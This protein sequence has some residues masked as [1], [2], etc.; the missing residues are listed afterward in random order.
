L[1]SLDFRA[2]FKQLRLPSYF[3]DI[4]SRQISGLSFPRRRE[5]IMS[6]SRGKTGYE[7]VP[8]CAGMTEF[9]DFTGRGHM[10]LY[11][12]KYLAF[13]R[14]HYP[15]LITGARQLVAQKNNATP[16][17]A[18]LNN[19]PVI[20]T[21]R[22]DQPA[23]FNPDLV[24]QLVTT[25]NT[26]LCVDRHVV[27]P[28]YYRAQLAEQNNVNLSEI[29]TNQTTLIKLVNEMTLIAC[30]EIL[31]EHGQINPVLINTL[32]LE[33]LP[34]SKRMREA[35]VQSFVTEMIM[36]V[37]Q[38]AWLNDNKAKNDLLNMIDR[39]TFLHSVFAKV[40]N[41]KTNACVANAVSAIWEDDAALAILLNAKTTDLLNI[42]VQMTTTSMPLP[43]LDKIFSEDYRIPAGAIITEAFFHE[44]KIGGLSAFDFMARHIGKLLITKIAANVN[45]FAIYG[46][47]WATDFNN[48]DYLLHL[49][50]S[51]KKQNDL[52]CDLSKPFPPFKADVV[53][54]MVAYFHHQIILLT[55][56][57]ANNPNIN[58]FV[59]K[60]TLFAFSQL[61]D[62]NGNIK[63][64]ILDQLNYADINYDAN[65]LITAYLR[66]LM[67][68]VL[69]EWLQ[70]FNH[71]NAVPS[72][73]YDVVRH[74]ESQLAQGLSLAILSQLGGFPTFADKQTVKCFQFALPEFSQANLSLTHCITELYAKMVLM[75]ETKEAFIDFDEEHITQTQHLA[76]TLTEIEKRHKIFAANVS[77]D[78]ILS[79]NENELAALNATAKKLDEQAIELDHQLEAICLSHI[80]QPLP[81]LKDQTNTLQ[82]AQ[83]HCLQNIAVEC[84]KADALN[85]RLKQLNDNIDNIDYLFA[86]G[87]NTE[88]FILSKTSNPG[89]VQLA[90]NRRIN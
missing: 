49:T 21:Y 7:W 60:I 88:A 89:N 30:Q 82:Q 69:A 16:L 73:L 65:Q 22:Q 13:L 5:S 43:T 14:I 25:L 53:R 71:L 86:F 23:P 70:E 40:L 39:K 74:I 35:L 17:S 34:D 83:T 36:P 64:E 76:D 37:M 29:L 63:A 3:G 42:L 68:T 20:H 19:F 61:L 75:A 8:A 55:V 57:V 2:Y 84:K 85:I 10:K 32:G 12:K 26:F 45:D 67:C 80:Y 24:L 77:V 79:Q 59:T 48:K 9:E 6:S 81:A 51:D 31:T 38:H 47:P 1:I 62:A 46:K 54:Q 27:N 4:I 90:A 87:N 66:K 28:V 78:E 41:A 56:D 50:L 18:I 11:F 33:N 44:L 72:Y 52:P 58:K 15:A